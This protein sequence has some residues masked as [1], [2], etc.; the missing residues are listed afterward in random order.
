MP[1][2]HVLRRYEVGHAGAQPCWRAAAAEV[3]PRHA[4]RV[5]HP[6]AVDGVARA[7]CT[8][9]EPRRGVVRL[10]DQSFGLQFRPRVARAVGAGAVLSC[11]EGFGE[12]LG[13]GHELIGPG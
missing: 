1:D 3:V 4:R 2:R 12:R 5:L 9:Q 7:D 13:V 10:V 11:C 8:R 6:V